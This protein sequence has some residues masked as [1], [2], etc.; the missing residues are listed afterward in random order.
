M[1][2][3]G[4]ARISDDD[5]SPDRQQSVLE[6]AACERIYIDRAT[7][8]RT[9]QPF[10]V[11]ALASLR[12]GDVF[13]VTRLDRLG[14]SVASL[15]DLVSGLDERGVAFRSLDE[16][17]DEIGP[18][19][20]YFFRTA[21]VLAGHERTVD[22]EAGL[23]IAR[24]RRDARSSRPQ[25]LGSPGCCSPTSSRCATSHVIWASRSGCCGESS[26][27]TRPAAR[28]DGVESDG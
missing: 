20:R 13:V 22:A 23:A 16:G 18:W 6:A 3:I 17:I 4:Y 5:A 24:R 11:D 28:G 7:G 2:V 27:T 9:R 19:G 15:L 21:A 10:L 25:G 12:E 8:R 1:A 26:R 14:G